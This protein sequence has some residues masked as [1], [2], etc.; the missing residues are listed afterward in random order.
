MVQAKVKESLSTSPPPAFRFKEADKATLAPAAG[1][2]CE[3]Q[4]GGVFL[5]TFQVRVVV[6]V[7]FVIVASKVLAPAVK[8]DDRTLTE[9]PATPKSL[10]FNF[11]VVEQVASLGIA[12]KS[13]ETVPTFDTLTVVVL[14]L[15]EVTEQSF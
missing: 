2:F 6:L 9:L 1:G 8:A 14:G 11:Q 12:L 10:P 3:A 15:L 13:V 4:V 5:Y 7:P